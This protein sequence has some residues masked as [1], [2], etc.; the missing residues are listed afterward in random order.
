MP[1]VL[2]TDASPRCNGSRETAASSGVWLVGMDDDLL[3]LLTV[4]M[5]HAGITSIRLHPA[6]AESRL[7]T[8]QPRMAIVDLGAPIGP[9]VHLLGA[10][11]RRAVPLVI[12]TSRE[13]EVDGLAKPFSPTHLLG[14]VE[15]ILTG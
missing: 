11:R 14:W 10:L 1:P 15:Q 8:S 3:D 2:T 4:T 7:E 12:V 13:G 5:G 6:E 9:H